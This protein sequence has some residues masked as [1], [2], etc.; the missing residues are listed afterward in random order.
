M[1]FVSPLTHFFITPLIILGGLA[2]TGFGGHFLITVIAIGTLCLSVAFSHTLSTADGAPSV[3]L[4]N[5]PQADATE[6]VGYTA[7][8]IALWR[9]GGRFGGCLLGDWASTPGWSGRCT[10]AFVIAAVAPTGITARPSFIM[11]HPPGVE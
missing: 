5:G 11:I 8:H 10:A 9:L 1:G 3:V 7:H 4:P 2:L 6:P